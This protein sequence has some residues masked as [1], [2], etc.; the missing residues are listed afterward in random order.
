MT[1]KTPPRQP[2]T[3]ELIGPARDFAVFAE[4]EYERRRNSD[5]DFDQDVFRE[6]VDVVLGK[7]R[8]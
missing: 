1:D 2:R 5:K 4:L 3:N 7:L 8:T 6:A